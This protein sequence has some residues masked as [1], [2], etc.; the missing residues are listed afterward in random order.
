MITERERL[1]ARLSDVRD[2]WAR[3]HGDV[4]GEATAAQEDEYYQE[5]APILEALADLRGA[6]GR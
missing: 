5:A 4:D 1:L 6:A 3:R 2:R